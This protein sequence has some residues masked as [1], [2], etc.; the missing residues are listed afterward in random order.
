MGLQS[1]CVQY[2]SSPSS[3][4]GMEKS[5]LNSVHFCTCTHTISVDPERGGPLKVFLKAGKFPGPN[6]AEISVHIFTSYWGSNYF[7]KISSGR[8]V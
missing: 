4:S 3:T 6:F 1:V 5:A 8:T 2:S 7:L